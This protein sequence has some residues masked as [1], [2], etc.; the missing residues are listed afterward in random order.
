MAHLV[1]SCCQLRLN[2]VVET[3]VAHARAVQAG[4]QVVH[5]AA[6]RQWMQRARCGGAWMAA[7]SPP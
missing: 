2:L 6:G 5:L 3:R 1:A 7:S 4:E